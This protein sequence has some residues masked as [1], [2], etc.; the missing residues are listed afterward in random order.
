MRLTGIA[1]EEADG[2]GSRNT[3]EGNRTFRTRPD[4][5][6]RVY[7]RQRLAAGQGGQGQQVRAG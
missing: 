5:R 1:E 2:E 6:S 4:G 3:E 7:V